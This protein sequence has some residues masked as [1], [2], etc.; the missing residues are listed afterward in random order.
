M[1]DIQQSIEHGEKLALVGFSVT[2]DGEHVALMALRHDSDGNEKSE[3]A[4]R[5]SAQ[6]W[7]EDRLDKCLEKHGVVSNE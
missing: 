1:V 2:S 7:T 6:P 3:F 4:L 5:S